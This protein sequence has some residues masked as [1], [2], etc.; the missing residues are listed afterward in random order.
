MT[1]S[2]LAGLRETASALHALCVKRFASDVARK[3]S[4]GA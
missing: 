1:G 4:G 3:F 2:L